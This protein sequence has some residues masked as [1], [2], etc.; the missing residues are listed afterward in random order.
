MDFSVILKRGK[1]EGTHKHLQKYS[2]HIER[3]YDVIFWDFPLFES[4]T[5]FLNE[6]CNIRQ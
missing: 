2:F 5:Y 1:K 4:G 6:K 3:E